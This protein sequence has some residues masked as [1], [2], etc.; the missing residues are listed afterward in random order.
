MDSQAYTQTYSFLPSHKW[1]YIIHNLDRIVIFLKQQ[2][3]IY[4][5]A[6]GL[7]CSMQ[8]VQLWHMN[9]VEA[10]VI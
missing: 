3:F 7:S 2:L 1:W 9:L 8:D 5:A 10:R 6:L 4:L